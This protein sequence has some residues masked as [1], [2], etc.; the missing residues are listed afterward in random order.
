MVMD[1]QGRAGA[2]RSAAA[3]DD[4]QALL[5][6]RPTAVVSRSGRG[7]ARRAGCCRPTPTASPGRRARLTRL[8]IWLEGARLPDGGT[9]DVRM[10]TQGNYLDRFGGTSYQFTSKP[11]VRDFQYRVTRADD[12]GSA[13]WSFPN[14]TYGYIEVDGVV[15]DEVSYA[16][17]Q[18]TPFAEWHVKVTRR[19]SGSVRPHPCGD[20]VRRLGQPADL[21][22]Y[23]GPRCSGERGG[24]AGRRWRSTSDG[25]GLARVRP[26]APRS[27]L[28][29]RRRT[30]RTP[31]PCPAGPRWPATAAADRP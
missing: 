9:V 28:E 2:L 15:D 29:V 23:V 1:Y 6:R 24:P 31:R 5:R 21:S 20:P 4:R 12:D 30:P 10:A 11:L 7:R 14:G 27:S 22:R 8:R 18:P 26:N 17:F 19:R 16:Y 13:D 25:C 3:D